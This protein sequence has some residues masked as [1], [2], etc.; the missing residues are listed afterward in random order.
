MAIS[1]QDL[2]EFAVNMAKAGASEAEL[3]AAISRA[4]YAAFHAL[5]PFA[6]KLPKSRVC[7]RDLNRVNHRELKERL[8]EWRT[9]D[10]SS[11]L[12]AMTATKSTLSRAVEAACNA[13][14]M[15]DYRMGIEVSLAEA[16]TQIER[17]K[18]ILRQAK[19]IQT[20]I[21]RDKLDD[22]AVNGDSVG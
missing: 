15:A 5:V 6:S 8:A 20:E 14:V 7:P 11:R 4:Y 10:V 13:R 17:V 1:E 9:D 18:R 21:D 12:R 19:Q 2:V 16:Q 22:L 3:R